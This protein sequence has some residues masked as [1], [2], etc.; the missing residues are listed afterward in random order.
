MKWSIDEIYLKTKKFESFY[1][2][3]KIKNKSDV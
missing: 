2:F 3:S 1:L